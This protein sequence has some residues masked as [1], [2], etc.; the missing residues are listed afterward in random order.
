MCTITYN[1]QMLISL[2]IDEYRFTGGAHGNTIRTSQTWNLKESKMIKLA[3]LFKDTNYVSALIDNIN[4]QIKNNIES[5]KNIYFEDYCFLTDKNFKV[6][7][8]YIKDGLINIFYQQYEIAP[9]SSGI[10]V[11]IIPR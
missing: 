2:Y 3:E 8:Y 10:I 11:F 1:Y 4:E 5:G 9:Y 6:E 7:N